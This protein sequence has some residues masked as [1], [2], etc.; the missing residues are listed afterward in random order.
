MKELEYNYKNLKQELNDYKLRASRV[1]QVK[2]LGRD[3]NMFLGK[4]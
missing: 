2:L 3:F 1:L 4:R